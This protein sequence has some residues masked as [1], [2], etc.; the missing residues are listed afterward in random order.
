MGILYTG[1]P[2]NFVNAYTPHSDTNPEEQNPADGTEA[3]EPQECSITLR[4]PPFLVLLFLIMKFH[5]L[6]V[7]ASLFSLF[8]PSSL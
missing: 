3:L 6:L 1:S 2:M 7:Y 8:S 4:H 5:F